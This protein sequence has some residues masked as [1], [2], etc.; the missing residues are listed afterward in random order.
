MA[1]AIA[2]APGARP[3]LGVVKLA[4]CDGCQLTL[5]DLEDELLA[6]AE[7]VDIV[8]FPEATSHR[9]DGPYDVLLVEGSVSTP[10]QA[11]EIRRLRREARTLITIGACAQ[12]GGIQAL[13]NW[14]SL[15]DVTSAVYPRPEEIPSLDQSTPVSERVAVDLELPG[16]PVSAS[17]L[18]EVLAATLIG[19]RPQLPNEAV[20]LDCKRRGIAC[21]LVTG[22]GPC[23]G[24][25]T[26]TGCGALCPSVG[27]GCFGCFGP[28]E[29]ANADGLAA[30]TS[31][32]RTFGA[33]DGRGL[34]LLPSP[35]FTAWAPTWRR[36]PVAT[37][38]P[39][40]SRDARH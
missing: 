19:R 35:L 15:A 25:L 33:A 27:R 8:E 17:Q 12:S 14:L 29:N 4:S 20:C 30:F 26:R 23:L 22:T 24:P 13:R 10:E 40:E 3:R 1:G 5:L 36:E 7:R 11:D 38:D 21:L 2:T 18:R 32:G 39:K 6:L 37:A 31:S 34:P 28:R 9:S 16:C